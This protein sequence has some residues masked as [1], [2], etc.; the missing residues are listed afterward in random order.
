MKIRPMLGVALLALSVITS[1]CFGRSEAQEAVPIRTPRP[2][3]TPTPPQPATPEAPAASQPAVENAAPVVEA[4]P[5]PEQPAPAEQAAAQPAEEAAAAPQ[6]AIAVINEDLI[7]IRRGPGLQYPVLKLGMRGDQYTLIGRSA[8]D[9]WWQICCIEELPGWITQ[10][11]VDADGP[12]DGIAVADP[13]AEVQALVVAPPTPEQAATAAPVVEAAPPVEAAPEAVTE[14][15]ATEEAPA[16]PPAPAF[17]FNLATQERFPESNDLVRVFLYVSQGDKAVPGYS[18]R[19]VHDGVEM[20]VTA[21]SA[22]QAG[23]T[24]P[25]A[26]PRQ[27]FQ[28]MKVEFP[29]VSS[30]GTWEIQLLDGGKAPAGPVAT[31]TLA[32]TDTDRELYVRYDKP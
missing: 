24:W 31:F 14:A 8:D 12:V 21:T 11:Y 25:T 5:V 20:P 29:G 9:E 27:R 18:L 13:D 2:T 28:N 10:Q 30:A 3:F 22:D 23:M 32:A 15:P 7:N 26:S 19:V 4:Q 1:G 16:E 6:T 17:E